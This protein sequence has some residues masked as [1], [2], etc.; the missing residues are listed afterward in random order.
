MLLKHVSTR[1]CVFWK[2]SVGWM[3]LFYF[4]LLE[5]SA[6]GTAACKIVLS[7]RLSLISQPSK[8]SANFF[9]K[10]GR[11][12]MRYRA[13]FTFL[14]TTFMRGEHM[15]MTFPVESFAMKDFKIEASSSR[16]IELAL[17]FYSTLPVAATI[18]WICNN[19]PV[20]F[21]L[22]KALA[23]I[24]RFCWESLLGVWE[25]GGEHLCGGCAC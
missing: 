22:F 4:H 11:E 9:Q 19:F 16:P 2:L 25:G 8:H 15:Q 14:S 10:E 13:F 12:S 7:F 1:Q 21:W 23:A 17:K 18:W 24:T 3:R 5:I 6:C 20:S